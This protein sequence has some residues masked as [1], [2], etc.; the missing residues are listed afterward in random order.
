MTKPKI[1]VTGATGK[2]GTQVVTQLREKDWPVRAI[3]HREDARSERLKKLGAEVVVADAYSPEQMIAAMNGVHRAY[4]CPTVQPFMIQASVVFA[5]AARE[6]R[7][8]SVVHLS[9]WIAAPA[10]PSIH[11]RQQWLNE[12]LMP[13][14]PDVSWTIVNPGVF[15]E[16][17]L[18]MMPAVANLG[19]MPNPFG[20]MRNAPPSNEDIARVAVGALI[21]PDKHHGKRYRPTG[22]DLLSMRDI[23]DIFARVLRRKVKMQPVSPS[24]FTKAAKVAGSGDFE[25]ANVLH[26]INDGLL[27]VFEV[28]APTNDVFELS[29]QH[30]EPF[31]QTVRRYAAFPKCQRTIGN[32]VRSIAEFAR[33]LT[34]GA[35]DGM[36]FEQQM[37]QPFPT[38]PQLAGESM[39]WR[40]EHARVNGIHDEAS[41]VRIV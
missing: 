29:G 15:A 1:L 4:Y 6:A 26:F 27:N 9:M 28:N 32:K 39:I 18:D 20:G 33:I 8:E 14:I 10:H 3:V 22:P 2:T 21:D 38:N 31:E 35:L 13:M 37:A 34:T 41:V 19:M 40:R 24:L 30:P 25:I 5:V 16:P 36:R 12:R 7:I 23:A 11:T 17:I